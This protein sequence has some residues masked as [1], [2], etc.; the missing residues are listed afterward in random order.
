MAEMGGQVHSAMLFQLLE[1]H[2]HNYAFEEAERIFD[3]SVEHKA[4]GPVR[5]PFSLLLHYI[6][7]EDEEKLVKITKQLQNSNYFN[8]A[9]MVDANKKLKRLLLGRDNDS[10][11]RL[12]NWMIDNK[13]APSPAAVTV[14]KRRLRESDQHLLALPTNATTDDN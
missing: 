9:L 12:H 11:L 14:L 8:D 2:V 13:L 5:G 6:Y 4:K 3:F 7:T 1:R 10:A